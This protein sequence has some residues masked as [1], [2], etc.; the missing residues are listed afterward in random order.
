M[1]WVPLLS[2]V[3]ALHLIHLIQVRGPA[4]RFHLVH[5][6]VGLGMVYMFAPWAEM[7]LPAQVPIGGFVAL[8]V[9]VATFVGLQLQMGRRDRLGR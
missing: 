9:L 5:L 8:T 3:C 6:L 4:R 7:P 2:A 1:L